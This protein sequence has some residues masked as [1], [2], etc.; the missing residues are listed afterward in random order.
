MDERADHCPTPIL[1][2]K[3]KSKIAPN[4]LSFAVN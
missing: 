1:A 3:K 2:L 4:I